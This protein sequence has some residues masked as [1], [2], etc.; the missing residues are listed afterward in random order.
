M[1]K[2][3]PVFHISMLHKYL[4]DESHILEPQT[5]DMCR[6]LSYSEQPIAIVD[7]EIRKLRSKWIPSV[8]VVWQH[9]KGQEATWE[10]EDIMRE[11]YPQLFT[12]PGMFA[13]LLI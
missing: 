7:R 9:H 12:E 13:P 8:R 1:D 10:S 4:Y 2:V 6:D 11:H 5:I 3:D